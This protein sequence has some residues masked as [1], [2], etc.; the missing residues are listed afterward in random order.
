[1]ILILEVPD[2]NIASVTGYCDCGFYDFTQSLHEMSG[3]L[4]LGH[5]RLLPCGFQ[6]I[7][8]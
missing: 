1:M 7:I 2:S 5:G 6:F 3:R 8:Y 4:K